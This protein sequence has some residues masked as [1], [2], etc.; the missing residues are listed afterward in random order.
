M[1]SKMPENNHEKTESVPK[2]DSRAIRR[3]RQA[4]LFFAFILLL[5][6]FILFIF[7]HTLHVTDTA[8][9][10]DSLKCDPILLTR[11]AIVGDSRLTIEI[12]ELESDRVQG[13]SGRGCLKSE[14]GMLFVYDKPDKHCFWMKDMKF[15]IDMIWFNENRQ[16]IKIDSRI[17]SNSYPEQSFCTN[18]AQYILEVPA[19]Y[20]HQQ[21][22]FNGTKLSY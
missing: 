11:Q 18:N 17:S 8:S 16:I 14:Q 9:G 15:D 21:G 13:L 22:W 20:A 10:G 7:N 2:P 6:V 3:Y 12:A 19:G 5:L 1:S 4:S